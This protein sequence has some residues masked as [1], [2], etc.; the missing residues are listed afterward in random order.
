M[1]KILF[2]H[3]PKTAG[4][5]LVRH[6]RAVFG[7][8]VHDGRY[9][10]QVCDAAILDERF[11]FYHGHFTRGF[12]LRFRRLVPD[13]LV[14]TFVR[15]PFNRLLS[16]YY[17]W[18]DPV[19]VGRELDVVSAA[20]GETETVRRLRAKF[21][22]VIFG[23]SL[24]GF[25]LSEDPDINQVTNNLQ[26]QYMT[27]VEAKPDHVRFHAAS[28]N[29]VTFYDFIGVQELYEPCLRILELKC[30][31]PGGSLGGS[32]RENANDINKTNGR[33]VVSASEMRLIEARSVYDLALYHVCY[34]LLLKEHGAWLPHPAADVDAIVGLPQIATLPARR[35]AAPGE[36]PAL[37]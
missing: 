24:S 11:T 33:Y 4:T 21:E 32:V 22:H 5:A 16:Q 3:I 27:L 37:L 17:N 26:A 30:G 31:L 1:T 35:P 13:A 23:M 20:S 7:D 9:D 14:F 8:R 6:A 34:A 29:A 19:R 15:H 10:E 2:H 36:L 28:I 12:V 18:S 25:L